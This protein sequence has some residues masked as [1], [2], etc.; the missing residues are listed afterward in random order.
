MFKLEHQIRKN[1]KKNSSAL[2]TRNQSML[3]NMEVNQYQ[4]SSTCLSNN[5][6]L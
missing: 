3:N 6:Q 5:L 1:I 2:Q 4:I